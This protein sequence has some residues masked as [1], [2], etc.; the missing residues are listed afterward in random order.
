MEKEYQKKI[1]NIDN[2]DEKFFT[3][4]RSLIDVEKGKRKMSNIS[5]PERVEDVATEGA[6]IRNQG[7]KKDIQLKER[8]LWILF[9][10]L[11][12]ET[13]AIFLFT[14][15]QAVGFKGFRLEEW[16]F[17]LLISGTLSQITVMLVIAVRHL[18]PNK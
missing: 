12:I 5:R 13:L 11:G 7:L 10:F 6:R 8:T 3:I 1:I 9:S 18:F 4:Y 16:S 15:F 17:R 14:F 2:D